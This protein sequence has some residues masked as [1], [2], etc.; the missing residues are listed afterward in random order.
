MSWHPLLSLTSI[1]PST[2][3]DLLLLP[4]VLINPTAGPFLPLLLLTTEMTL[5]ETDLFLT[6]LVL[7]EDL[8]EVLL[9]L[10]VLRLLEV[11]LLYVLLRRLCLFLLALKV[12]LRL[13]CLV[14]LFLTPVLRLRGLFECFFE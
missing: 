12:L 5:R 1:H 10:E 14:F 6:L 9:F 3:K 7:L 2:H 11:F 13:V 8:R 4:P